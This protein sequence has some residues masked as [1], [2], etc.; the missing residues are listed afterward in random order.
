MENLKVL[1]YN[2]QLLNTD[3][4]KWKAERRTGLGWGIGIRSANNGRSNMITTLDANI[5]TK[6]SIDISAEQQPNLVQI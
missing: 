3:D 2:G 6:G 5:D 4:S 1:D